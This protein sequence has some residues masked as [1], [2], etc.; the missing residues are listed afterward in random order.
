MLVIRRLYCETCKRIHHE[1][2]D[3]VVPY[4]RYSKEVIENIVYGQAAKD[5]PCPDETA[6]SPCPAETARRI[7]GWWAAVKGYFFQILLTLVEK[8]GARFGEPPAFK[9]TVRAVA[10]A[11]CW[12]FAHQL[13]T[14][15]AVRPG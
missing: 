2:P 9:E 15:S 7:R 1:L 10:N 5:A 13:C 3:C 4:K 6:G 8:Y 12:I 11:N 14:R